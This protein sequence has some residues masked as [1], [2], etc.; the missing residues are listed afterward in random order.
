MFWSWPS[1]PVRR[2]ERFLDLQHRTCHDKSRSLQEKS[3]DS[4]RN[5]DITKKK[6]LTSLD[7]LLNRSLFLARRRSNIISPSHPT[8]PWFRKP[9]FAKVQVTITSGW[10]RLAAVGRG[11]LR[12]A[13]WPPEC[14]PKK[15]HQPNVMSTF[16]ERNRLSTPIF[17]KHKPSKSSNTP[18]A[19]TCI[20]CRITRKK[21]EPQS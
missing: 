17:D 14:G 9:F 10:L 7:L 1:T 6:K 11:C 19:S 20:A 5:S 18:S 12:L 13:A 15:K 8:H 3:T 4:K 16:H 2:N 21:K